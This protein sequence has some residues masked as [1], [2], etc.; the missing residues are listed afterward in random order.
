MELA[1]ISRVKV[2][3]FG[4]NVNN[5]MTTTTIGDALMRNVIRMASGVVR[6]TRG[7]RPVGLM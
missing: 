5:G 6:V 7:E 2:P 1:I 3:V 4:L